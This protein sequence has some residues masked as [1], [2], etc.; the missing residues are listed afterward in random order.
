MVESVSFNQK[1]RV[2]DA[3][4][5][6]GQEEVCQ[7][8]KFIYNINHNIAVQNN[9][10]LIASGSRDRTVRVWDALTVSIESL[11]C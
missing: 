4:K 1:S 10:V 8:I 2:L 7:F 9:A 3:G 11:I 6:E 5:S